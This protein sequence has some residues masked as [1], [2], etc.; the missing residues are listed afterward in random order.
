M[1]I[2]INT[3]AGDESL[4]SL[5]HRILNI[6]LI[7]GIIICFVSSIINFFLGL[8]SVLILATLFGGI[9]FA[10]LYYLSAIKQQYDIP[11]YLGLF[12]FIFTPIVWIYNSG[13]LGGIPYYVIVFSVMIS[14]LL[15]GIKR[16]A[17]MFCLIITTG[18]LIILEYKYP[19]LI[20]GYINNMER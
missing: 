15:S 19:F 9:L 1:K 3:L 20:K 7:F 13:T 12:I 5:E 18:A 2:R 6:I 17:F 10:F 16:F 4:F 14:T 8:G 11:V